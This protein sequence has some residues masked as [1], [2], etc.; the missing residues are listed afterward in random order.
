LDV[1]VSVKVLCLNAGSSS[2]KVALIDEGNVVTRFGADV[3][4]ARELRKLV[5]SHG[6]A[7]PDAIGHRLV[8]GGPDQSAPLQLTGPTRARLDQAIPFAPLHLP[9]ELAVVDAATR[10]YPGVPQ[11]ACFDTA[12]HARLP[13]VARRLPIDGAADEAGVRRYGFHGLSYEYVVSRLGGEALDLAVIAHLGSGAS[14]AA[15]H[16]GRSIDT[17]MGMSPTGGLMMGTRSG[18]LDP[19]ALVYLMVARKWG[20]G[21]IEHYVNHACGL[22]GVSGTTA[23]MEKLL[24]AREHDPLAHLAVA[25]F[26]YTAAKTVGALAVALGGLR[27]LVFTGGMGAH[28]AAIRAEI[29][30]RLAFLGVSLDGAKNAAH[31]A[32]I[33]PA[34]APCTVHVIETDEESVIAHHVER[35]LGRASLG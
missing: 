14:M 3:A 11:V 23:D 32:I 21:E 35:C 29:V 25:L 28:A 15:V 10:A 19:G 24:V 12:F 8:H 4:E 18:D 7:R 1:G 9:A 17:T 20:A 2:L 30:N 5:E 31:A 6:I 13:D 27:T 22:L 26:V 16:G 34:G 33:S